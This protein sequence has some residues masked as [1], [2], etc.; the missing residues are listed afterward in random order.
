MTT[1]DPR[2]AYRVIAEPW[3]DHDPG[4]DGHDAF[5]CAAG[6]SL[7]VWIRHPDQRVPLGEWHCLGATQTDSGGAMN[8][9]EVRDVV[10]DYVQA[11]AWPQRS[12]ITRDR[13]E[14]YTRVTS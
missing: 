10:I 14:V 3:Y 9:D 12:N 13:I 7:E 8:V 5:A 11:L 1:V 4:D 2:P 6:F